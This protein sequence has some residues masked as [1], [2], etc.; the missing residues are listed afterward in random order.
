MEEVPNAEHILDICIRMSIVETSPCDSINIFSSQ[1]RGALFLFSSHQIYG[2]SKHIAIVWQQL[3]RTIFSCRNC[4][5]FHN[6]ISS[7]KKHSVG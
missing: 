2:E 5:I 3:Q 6:N 4:S 7:W 1:L